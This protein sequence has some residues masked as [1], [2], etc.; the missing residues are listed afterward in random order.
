MVL[1]GNF[2]S[3]FFSE[4]LIKIG[5]VNTTVD[6]CACVNIITLFLEK[7]KTFQSNKFRLGVGMKCYWR[8][9]T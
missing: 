3:H 5:Y 6:T 9:R 8:N 1:Y 2:V 4:F 7:Y